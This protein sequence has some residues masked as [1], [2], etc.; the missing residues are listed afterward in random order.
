MKTRERREEQVERYFVN[1]PYPILCDRIDEIVARGLPPEIV[2]DASTLDI[3]DPEKARR[4]A[5][6]LRKAGLENTIHGPFKDLSPGG[7]DPKIQAVTRERFLQT[8]ELAEIFKPRCVVFH[9]GYDPWRFQG[10]EH[11]WL[12]NS[13]ETWKPLV[14]RAEGIDTILAV[15]NVF[16]KEPTTLLSLLE[17]IQSPRFRHCFDV[18]HL[19]VFADT[20]ME[21]WIE[22][23]APYI[24]EIHLHDNDSS[25]DDHLPLGK[26]SIDFPL[27]SRLIRRYMKTRPIHSLEP[28]R[29]EDLEASIQGFLQLMKEGDS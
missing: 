12:K 21:E 2:L 20:P 5:Q 22:T 13:V 4:S 8:I 9:S 16:E 26:G 25:T 10:Y 27:L 28:S 14:E 23:M 3:P 1:I 7:V 29:E 6:K 15:E 18:G 17:H 11:L 24:A 19:N